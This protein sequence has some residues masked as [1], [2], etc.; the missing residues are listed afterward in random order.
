MM[1]RANSLDQLSV[2]GRRSLLLG[3]A[4]VLLAPL[5]GCTLGGVSSGGPAADNY[6]TAMRQAIGA[7]TG[8]LPGYVFRASPVGNFGVGSVYVDEMAGGDLAQV[9]SNWFLGSP[10]TWLASTLPPAERQRSIERVVSEGTMGT[11]RLDSTGSRGIQAQVGIALVAALA[12]NAGLEAQ[13]GVETRLQADEVRQRRLNWA[14]FQAALRAGQIGREVADIVSKGRFVLAAAD[15]VLTGYRAEIAV[16]ES[17]AP[18]LAVHLRTRALL[19]SR[20]GVG[21]NLRVAESARGR[22]VVSSTQPVV[23]AVLFKRPPPVPKDGNPP[24]DLDAWPLAK[25][26]ERTAAAVESKVIKAREGQ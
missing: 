23:A 5:G 8:P 14:E 16:D 26:S 15:I 1:T 2:Q 3:A 10:D 18:T 21:A 4:T 22:F 12:G 19:P 13:R 25:V 6:G 20:A 24:S 9:E 11:F 17:R 7:V